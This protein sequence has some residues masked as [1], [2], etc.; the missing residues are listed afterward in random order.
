M[1]TCQRLLVTWA[2]GIFPF[3][4]LHKTVVGHCY[5]FL[6]KNIYT[7]GKKR[8]WKNNLSLV[9]SLGLRHAMF[10]DV[11][12]FFFKVFDTESPLVS[13]ILDLCGLEPKAQNLKTCAYFVHFSRR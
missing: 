5:S 11:T 3:D 13:V 2:S 9:S 1:Q 8:D 10:R 7:G 4:T 12:H 6:V